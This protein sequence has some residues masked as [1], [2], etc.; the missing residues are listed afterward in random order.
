MT[1]AGRARALG[2][3]GVV[4]AAAV[5]LGAAWMIARTP[6]A[7][8]SHLGR[9]VERGERGVLVTYTLPEGRSADQIA[10]ISGRE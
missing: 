1:A 6:D 9:P 10:S 7:A 4:V 5:A 2:L 8:V 3:L